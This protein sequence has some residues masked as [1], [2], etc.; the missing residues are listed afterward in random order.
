MSAV[1]PLRF[2][3]TI[4][5]SF[6]ACLIASVSANLIA[7]IGSPVIEPIRTSLDVSNIL[8]AIHAMYE[9]TVPLALTVTRLFAFCV[10]PADFMTCWHA[11][12]SC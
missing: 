9:D 1:S 6:A 12:G 8:L 4:S 11:E 7:I 5:V 10:W 3:H 2:D